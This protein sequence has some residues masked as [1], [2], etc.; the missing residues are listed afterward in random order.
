MVLPAVVRAR[1]L[2]P[3]GPSCGFILEGL[4]VLDFYTLMF[5]PSFL[6]PWGEVVK[7]FMFCRCRLSCFV[8]RTWLEHSCAPL[9]NMSVQDMETRISMTAIPLD[10]QPKTSWHARSQSTLPQQPPLQAHQAHLSNDG[11]MVIY[12]LNSLVSMRTT[13]YQSR[14]S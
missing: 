4:V 12:S 1:M 9:H 13:S 2:S 7:F 11:Y 10:V 3:S 8:R 5:R 14:S 6:S